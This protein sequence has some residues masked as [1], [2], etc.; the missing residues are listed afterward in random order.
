MLDEV[1]I[2]IFVFSR[3]VGGYEADPE[4]VGG[5]EGMWDDS[6]EVSIRPSK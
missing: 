5:P 4:F 6:M 2:G 3:R 1:F